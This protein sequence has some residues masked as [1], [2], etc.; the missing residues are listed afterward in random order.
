M[1]QCPD[2]GRSLD[3]GNFSPFSKIIC[4]HC[5]STVRVRT[6][7]GQYEITKMLGE[8]GMSQVFKAT[9]LTLGREVALKILHRELSKDSNLTAMFEREAK[10]TASIHHPNVVKVF[11]VGRDQGYFYIAMEMVKGISLEQHIAERGA[12][13]EEE[14]L[15]IA[16]DVTSGLNAAYQE[17]LI[18]RDIK[19]GNML[20]TKRGTAKLVD[21][22]LAMQQ[23]I[24]DEAED[25]WATP[26]YVPPEK[27]DG[28][29]DTFK[30]DIYSL[31][32][33]LFHALAGHPP[34]AANTSSLDELKEIKGAPISLKDSVENVSKGTVKLVDKMMANDPADRFD[35]YE[36]I[37][38]AIEDVQEKVFGT[39][40]GRPSGG[41]AVSTFWLKLGGGIVLLL[42]VLALAVSF[43]KRE[44]TGGDAIPGINGGGGERVISAAARKQSNQ[45]L[46]GRKYMMAG[47]F[48]EAGKIFNQL[49]KE[50]DLSPSTAAWNQFYQ[51]LNELFTGHEKSAR[52]KFS[53][54]A[55]LK[56]FAWN[57]PELAGQEKFLKKVGA[58]MD[59]DLPLLPGDKNIFPADTLQ[60][61]GLLAGGLK[62]WDM[63]QFQSGLDWFNLFN[64]SK[65]PTN[66]EWISDFKPLLEAYRADFSKV[67]ENS[68]VPSR[69]SDPDT[70]KKQQA[71]LKKQLTQLQTQ[72]AAP[73]WI[74]ARIDRIDTILA[75]EQE[76]IARKAEQRRKEEAARKARALAAASRKR[77]MPDGP[78][79]LKSLTPEEMAEIS[80]LR[81]LV[82]TFS[83]YR[84]TLL[85]SNAVLKL[86]TETFQTEAGRLLQRDLHSAYQQADLFKSTLSGEL[87]KG[88]YEGIIRRRKGVDLDGKITSATPEMFVVDLGFGP[89]EVPVEEFDPGWL[90]DTAEAVFPPFSPETENSWEQ[91]AWFAA[92]NGLIEQSRRIAKQIGP[93]LPE[94]A[95]RFGRLEALRDDRG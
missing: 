18:H 84:E 12:L 32:A 82:K 1:N 70:L 9:D 38:H 56:S 55:S 92:A 73:A 60:S 77:R 81:E 17:N 65:V 91:L 6:L 69:K 34:F 85:F 25:I 21:F 2:C 93:L 15:N 30:G 72:G 3:V 36:E 62:N 45:F 5:D 63:G 80:R 13:S 95:N 79:V 41:A 89:N 8:G 40:R 48:Q 76:E 31:G 7:L 24:T 57:N 22:G 68:P 10:L 33:T 20:V 19:P 74:Q 50:G 90:V 71:L 59:Q 64:S 14:V 44:N 37:L 23:G 42:A 4:P 75:Q 47:N 39:K 27:L 11:T 83:G 51:G 54:L 87:N 86:D 29:S 16:H 88:G 78:G 43:G 66:Y 61:L 35:S 53:G 52:Q 28:E 46:E 58:K 26:F 67:I 49:S 94:F